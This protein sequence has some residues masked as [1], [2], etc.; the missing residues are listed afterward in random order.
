MIL[1]DCKKHRQRL[2]Q[3]AGVS[4]CFLWS[5]TCRRNPNVH[6]LIQGARNL[7]KDGTVTSTDKPPSVSTI[8]TFATQ[9]PTNDTA[10]RGRNSARDFYCGTLCASSAR[11]KA[12]S[13]PLRKYIISCRWQ[14]VVRTTKATLVALCKKLPFEDH[15]Q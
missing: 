8:D 10:A 2:S 14:M 15:D 13:L 1:L 6:A 4:A 12:D 7:S 9:I 3:S 5:V 11:A